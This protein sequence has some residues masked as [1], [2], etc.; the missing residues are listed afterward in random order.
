M[1]QAREPRRWKRAAPFA[2][3]LAALL[4]ASGGT[5]WAATLQVCP[6]G[7]AYSTIPAAIAAASNG[8]TI[9]IAAGTYAGGFFIDKN[10]TLVGADTDSVTISGGRPVVTVPRA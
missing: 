1:R 9:T 6:S 8:D 5:A 7:C 10:L 2:F 3:L 4:A